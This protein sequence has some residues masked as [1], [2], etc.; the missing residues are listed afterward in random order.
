MLGDRLH[1]CVGHHETALR[2]IEWKGYDW[3]VGRRPF[4]GQHLEREPTR[5]DDPDSYEAEQ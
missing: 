5:F 1:F 2:T 3:L 4:N